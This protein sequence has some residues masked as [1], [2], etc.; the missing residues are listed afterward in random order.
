MSIHSL[1]RRPALCFAFTAVGIAILAN[2]LPAQSVGEVTGKVTT[3][4]NSPIVG[5]FISVDDAAPAAQTDAQGDFR[6]G[7]VAPGSHVLHVRRSGYVDSAD[8]IVVATDA[9]TQ[10]NISLAEKVATLA[11]VTV[12]GTK[13]DLAET[14]EQLA[15]I[16]GAVAMVEA[17]EIR[18]TRQANLKDVLQF[19]PGVYIQPRFGAADESQISIRGSGLRDNFHA[20][21][22]NLLVNGMPYRNADGFTDFESLEM[23]TTEAIEVYKG[24]NALRYGGSTMGGAINLDTKTGYSSSPTSLFG[25]GGS[26]G[27]Y[28][29]QLESGGTRGASDYYASYGHTSL[30]GYRQWSAQR[31][32]RVNLHGGYRLSD[33]TDAR[34]FYFF[35]H[36]NE[37]LPGALT[38][39]TFESDPRSADPENVL[40][41]WGRDYDL[42]HVG[43]QLRTQIS[44]SQ[45]L[46][47]SPYMQYR[48]IDHPIFQVIAQVSHDYGAE[49]RYENTGD[50]GALNNRLTLGFQPAHESLLNQQYENDAGK[51]GALT[52]NQHDH[53]TSVALYAEDVL[54]LT[55]QL[56]AVVGV[57][58]DRATRKTKDFFLSDGDQSDQRTFNPVSPKVGFIYSLRSG[59]AQIF[60]NASR[61]YEPPL[62]LELNSLT[63][64]GYIPLEGQS[65]WQYELGARGRQIGVSWDVSAYDIELTNEILNI[66]VQP[67]PGAPFTVPTYR[68]APKTRHMGLEAGLSYQLPGALFVRGDVSDHLS[69][70]TS[71]TLARYTFVE[72]SSY[73]GNDIPG[74]PRQALS[75]EVKYTH[76]SGFSFAPTVEWIPQSYFLDS[77]NTVTNDGWT[78]LSL[79]AEWATA[80]GMTLFAAG[81]NLANRRFSQSVQV[82]N[83]AG[84]YYE[85]ADGRSFYAGLR[86]TP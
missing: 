46:E 38:R 28:K 14:R 12:I 51:H 49:V 67:F 1:F 10:I 35:A 15:K 56:A 81:Q 64:P 26:F 48:D 73:K 59:A 5:A 65:A 74:A 45:R 11:G 33:N 71:Y 20:R 50:L 78:N 17:P 70:R 9:P 79:R 68:N 86:W 66:N 44:P 77:Q 61:S 6:I 16:P 25:E 47:I 53:A 76:P 39:A 43:L 18:A 23:L 19:V 30:G 62:L 22:V 72:D 58:A 80:Y 41:R 82:D 34:M 4:G 57:R 37:E 85:P 52:K 21:G 63:V 24:G 75:A 69:F 31:R 2:N 13:T 83:A 32:D 36:V 8:S 60:G 29:T 7:G 84:Q 40:N 42:H 55:S 27:F 3:V 54:S